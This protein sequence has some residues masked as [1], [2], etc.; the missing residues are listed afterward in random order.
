MFWVGCVWSF[1]LFSRVTASGVTVIQEPRSVSVTEGK[2]LHLSCSFI[3]NTALS[4]NNP[5]GSLIWYKDFR[6]SIVCNNCTEYI[7]RVQKTGSRPFREFKNGS[8]T[9]TG[10]KLN[11]TGR[12]YCE[13]VLNIGGK[14]TGEGT[15]VTVN[16]HDDSEVTSPPN[17]GNIY[18]LIFSVLVLVLLGLIL[19]KIISTLLCCGPRDKRTGTQVVSKDGDRSETVP[20]V[21]LNIPR[22][23]PPHRIVCEAVRSG[24]QNQNSTASG[25]VSLPAS[26]EESVVSTSLWQPDYNEES[27]RF[28]PVQ[29]PRRMEGQ[30]V[31]AAVRV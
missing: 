22:S 11:D 2:T 7:G 30:T 21:E 31:Y 19:V 23:N 25:S 4:G 9:I 6:T 20:H 15:E 24:G 10:V 26:N 1:L 16:R 12:Y 28:E 29:A 18:L 14:G 3:V 13:V 8:V 5:I 27:V 17:Q